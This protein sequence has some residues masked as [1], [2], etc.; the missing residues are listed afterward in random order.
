[1]CIT[2]T[3]TV[4]AIAG[5]GI[6]RVAGADVGTICVSTIMLTVMTT[7][8]TLI[9]DSRVWVRVRYNEQPLQLEPVKQWFCCY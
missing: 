4:E 5:E 1:M 2:L 6:A 7:F 3:A 8:I 9:H